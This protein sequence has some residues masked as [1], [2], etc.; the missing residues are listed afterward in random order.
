MPSVIVNLP[1]G[2][3]LRVNGTDD[4]AAARAAAKRFWT[5]NPP[6]APQSTT[7]QV[8]AGTGKILDG[9]LPGAG[10]FFGGVG[11]AAADLVD[12]GGIHLGDSYRSGHDAQKAREAQLA[13]DHPYV[14]G[15]LQATGFL[16]TLP[17]AFTKASRVAQA[18]R[19]G[20]AALFAESGRAAGLGATLA[21]TSGAMSSD[22]GSF[23]QVAGDAALAGVTGGT[24]GALAPTATR[25]V[26][27]AVRPLVNPI[28][29]R[30]AP[31]V[32]RALSSFGRRVGLDG[33]EA[34]GL[35]LQTPAAVRQAADAINERMGTNARKPFTNNR[36]GARLT[37]DDLVAEAD[38]RTAMGVPSS[39]SDISEGAR[40]DAGAALRGS[41]GE[42][43][44]AMRRRIYQ[45]QADASGRV[46]RHI[47][48]TLGP[49]VNPEVQAAGLRRQS[50]VDST[51][52]YE[53]AMAQD[54][55]FTE[56]LQ[57]LFRRPS[58]TAALQTAGQELLDE[59]I[60]PATVGL[61]MREGQWVMGAKPTMAAYDKV[62][63]VL[64]RTV[65]AGQNKFAAPAVTD[66]SR[67]AATIRSEL[68]GILD[69][70]VAVP[71]STMPSSAAAGLNPFYREA[72]QAA[73]EP[74]QSARAME[75]GQASAAG[76]TSADSIRFE[77]RDMNPHQQDMYRL[78]RRTDMATKARQSGDYSN[79]GRSQNGNLENRM[80]NEEAF[81][82]GPAGALQDRLTAE[83]EVHQT[84]KGIFGG[85][86]TAERLSDQAAQAEALGAA[87]DAASG[88]WLN[89][90]GRVTKGVLKGEDLDVVRGHVANVLTADD[91]TV[92]RRHMQA[93]ANREERSGQVAVRKNR[94]VTTGVRGAANA[95]GAAQ[96]ALVVAQ[97]DPAEV[98][99]LYGPFGP[100]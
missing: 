14:S 16:A 49:T 19:A 65:F 40:R 42:P 56:G 95:A 55:P 37:R 90:A 3:K 86:A 85:P 75:A 43:Q 81:G 1:D 32:G 2:R 96:G 21:G 76:N 53:Q 71:G 23:S 13:K 46:D 22:A 54:I 82:A 45:K 48:E 41:I 31:T 9:V 80:A 5:K 20:K 73:A 84:Y 26:G 93:L 64:D 30:V 4:P 77:M 87:S 25:L 17:M 63:K 10:Q 39:A 88:N 61:V 92:I 100:Q 72:R 70:P 62:K 79:L 52:L 78:G 50:Q 57:N 97:P 74:I 11:S 18:A 34:E 24:I 91:A 38:R 6:K 8:R 59:G 69:G 89:L 35:A 12:G 47:T 7:D 67:G 28:I 36:T 44:D 66:A 68:L 15:G 83:H 29:D 94:M 51:P 27:A 58:A 60:N 99:D 98:D 33:L